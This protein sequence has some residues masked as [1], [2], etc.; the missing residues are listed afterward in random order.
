MGHSHSCECPIPMGYSYLP[1][2]RMEPLVPSATQSQEWD[3]PGHFSSILKNWV[4]PTIYHSVL[5]MGCFL[6]STIQA[7]QWHLHSCLPNGLKDGTFP[8][9]C[10]PSSI[11]GLFFTIHYQSSTIRHF[12]LS[13]LKNGTFPAIC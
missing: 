8:T 12:L 7:Q 11:I 13:S 5:I 4:F 1:I 3:L 10:H 9:I 2:S 6:L